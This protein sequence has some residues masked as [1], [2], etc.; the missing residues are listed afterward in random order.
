MLAAAVVASL[1]LTAWAG[2]WQQV[3]D[4]YKYD[5]DGYYVADAW[6]YIGG[7]WYHFGPDGVMQTRWVKDDGRWYWLDEQGAMR[8]GWF[9]DGDTWYYLGGDGAM[10]TGWFF[11]NDKW[12]YLEPSGAMAKDSA[13]LLD[14]SI[15]EF[16]ASGAWVGTI[17]TGWL[18]DSYYNIPGNYRIT[19]PGEHVAVPD[20]E[21]FDFIVQDGSITVYAST[22][23]VPGGTAGYTDAGLA[24]AMG[25]SFKSN[26]GSYTLAGEEITAV[27]T[28]GYAF[29]KMAYK[30]AGNTDALV[31]NDIYLRKTPDLVHYL[32]I[33]YPESE[34]A[35]ADAI[36]AT[37]Q[38]LY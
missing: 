26:L 25:Q 19:A 9:L 13:W 34:Q 30:L 21:V 5:E 35:K 20:G 2:T 1:S 27:Q 18:D 28:G 11:E 38:K 14:G 16:D 24:A 37:Y 31:H 33:S 4:T 6:R 12:Y 36:L 32:T 23:A 8:T 3:G 17:S 10:V 22:Q 29:T 15:Y 7:K